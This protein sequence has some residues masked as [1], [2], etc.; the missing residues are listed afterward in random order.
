[1]HKS[2]QLYKVSFRR[3]LMKMVR[4]VEGYDMMKAE[5]I[6]DLAIH[7]LA[8]KQTLRVVCRGRTYLANEILK[9]RNA[10]STLPWRLNREK[11]GNRIR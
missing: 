7:M 6:M 8:N 5:W 9:A 10:K 4:A 3:V 2:R 1:M 11:S